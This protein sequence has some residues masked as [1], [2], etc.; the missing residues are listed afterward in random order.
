MVYFV[1]LFRYKLLA[2]TSW[3]AV[4][5]LDKQSYKTKA[6]TLCTLF[7]NFWEIIRDCLK[8]IIC[9]AKVLNACMV[10]F[11]QGRET[12]EQSARIFEMQ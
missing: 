1:C 3:H 8:N 7:V 5:S 9:I 2:S 12:V 6:V 11:I 10:L 4:D